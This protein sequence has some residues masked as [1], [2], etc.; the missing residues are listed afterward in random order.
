MALYR[1]F[2][3]N[4]GGY[5]SYSTVGNIPSLNYSIDVKDYDS[6]ATKAIGVMM[7]VPAVSGS[8]WGGTGLNIIDGTVLSKINGGIDGIVEFDG[9][10]VKIVALSSLP[11]KSTYAT[12]YCTIKVIYEKQ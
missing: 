2:E 1:C 5:S 9:T 4:I 11:N 10:K 3:G 12:L 6:S 7:T 8:S